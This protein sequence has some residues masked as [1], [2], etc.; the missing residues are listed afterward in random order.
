MTLTPAYGRD[1]KSGKAAKED[2]L[3]GKDFVVA[4]LVHRYSGGYCNFEDLRKDGETSV[5]IRYK[6]LT[7]IVVVRF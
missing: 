7:Q 1:Y 2:F 4:D 3:A 6:K 5:N